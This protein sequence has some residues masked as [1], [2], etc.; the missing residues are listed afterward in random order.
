MKLSAPSSKKA[1]NNRHSSKARNRAAQPLRVPA[2]SRN[3]SGNSA[4]CVSSSSGNQNNNRADIGREYLTFVV[5]NNYGNWK[6]VRVTTGYL[7]CVNNPHVYQHSDAPEMLELWK[8]VV[9]D[10]AIPWD[11]S[12]RPETLRVA[13]FTLQIE[14]ATATLF[15]NDAAVADFQ[16]TMALAK[17]SDDEAKLL[18]LS[19]QKAKQKLFH[20]PAFGRSDQKL[21]ESLSKS[22]AEVDLNDAFRD[23]SDD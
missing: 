15:E 10:R 19:Q 16:R 23:L 21:M 20:D 7:D 18:G 2:L 22:V 6:Y 13:R 11:D 4:K 3:T 12:I 17:L 14:E 1:A 8:R 5:Q 9:V